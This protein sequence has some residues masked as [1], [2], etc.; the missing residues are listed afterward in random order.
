[1]SNSSKIIIAVIG[2][3]ICA[4]IGYKGMDF[5]SRAKENSFGSSSEQGYSRG[6]EVV[7]S[8]SPS[9]T[10]PIPENNNGESI[11]QPPASA[12]AVSTGS[13]APA[14]DKSVALSSSPQPSPETIQTKNA[15]LQTGLASSP[16]ILSVSTP[17]YDNASKTYSFQV[18]ASGENLTFTVADAKKK[19]VQSNQTGD[20]RV[21]PS[22]SGKY[23]VYVTDRFGNKSEYKE[24]KGFYRPVNKVTKEELQQ[25]LNSGRAQSAID[26]NFPD[27]VFSGC[28]YEFVGIHEDEDIPRSYNEILNRIRMRTWSSVTVLSVSHNSETNKLVRARIQVN[29]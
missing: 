23:Y 22:S 3:I 16:E 7:E 14:A 21:Q 15:N 26:A 1:M 19:D 12:S 17:R 25:I 9:R 29:Y 6:S 10:I 5:L 20:F 13:A 27:R 28:K 11:V 18:M 8:R 4:V 24:V 2:F